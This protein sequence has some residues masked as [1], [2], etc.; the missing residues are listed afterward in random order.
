M[1]ATTYGVIVAVGLLY[2]LA[3][4]LMP[5]RREWNT[6]K[7]DVSNDLISGTVAYIIM[8]IFLKPFYIAPARRGD[9]LAG[10]PVRQFPLAQR[11]A[12]R[13]PADPDAAAR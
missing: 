9:G 1:P 6:P 10:R 12:T 5:Y 11:L 13:L 4:W 3:E 7:G 2:W 8:P